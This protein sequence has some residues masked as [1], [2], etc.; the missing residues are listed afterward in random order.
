VP[1][2]TPGATGTVDA[3]DNSATVLDDGTGWTTL[4]TARAGTYTLRGSLGGLLR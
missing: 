3:T 2:T 4:T 1:A